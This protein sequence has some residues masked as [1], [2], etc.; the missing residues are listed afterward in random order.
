MIKEEKNSYHHGNLKE[1]L[2]EEALNIIKNESL[3]TLTLRELTTRVGA[4]RSAIYRHFSNKEDML[5]QVILAGFEQ[6]DEEMAP[7]FE[8]SEL[9]ILE[10][11]ALM[12]SSYIK[13]AVDN[14]NL[15]RLLFGPKHMKEREEVCQS[16]KP[17]LHEL[18][19][20]HTGLDK[21]D[22]MESNGFHKLVVLIVTA[23]EQKIFK[24][25]NPLLLATTIWS[26]LHGLS[27]LIIDGHDFGDFDAQILYQSNLE[28]ILNGLL[29]T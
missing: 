14:P 26:S 12:G 22:E 5:K 6:L 4:S 29:I 25:Q 8:N 15:Y 1:A 27:S 11:F 2:L 16:Q 13:F 10:K 24:A 7:I 23:Q 19:T 21:L 17:E 18:K 28:T 20:N 3:E 9:P